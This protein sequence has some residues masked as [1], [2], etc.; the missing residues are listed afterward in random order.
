LTTLAT[1]NVDADLSRKVALS[2][3]RET[4]PTSEEVPLSSR[5]G[6]VELPPF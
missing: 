5:V 6:E 3:D 2:S 4:H 1:V